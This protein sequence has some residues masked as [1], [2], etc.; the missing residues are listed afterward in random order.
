FEA[1]AN[2]FYDFVLAM[3]NQRGQRCSHTS[4]VVGDEYTHTGLAELF[5]PKTEAMESRREF[6]NQSYK[7]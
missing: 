3:R 6:E 1:G 5:M 2:D 7:W 4:L